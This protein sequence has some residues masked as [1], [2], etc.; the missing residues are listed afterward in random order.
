M[1]L[2]SDSKISK[3]FRLKKQ[4]HLSAYPCHQE[5]IQRNPGMLRV[6]TML[7]L[8]FIMKTRSQVESWNVL[9]TKTKINILQGQKT[10]S[11]KPVKKSFK[12]NKRKV[13]SLHFSEKYWKYFIFRNRNSKVFRK[14]FIGQSPDEENSKIEAPYETVRYI[15]P[16]PP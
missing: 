11:P 13:E 3:E 12:S 7:S 16:S 2:W 6:T 9:K 4:Q 10:L 8:E 5:R 14:S 1:K 15:S